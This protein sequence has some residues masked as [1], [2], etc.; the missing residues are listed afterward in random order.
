MLLKKS[1]NDFI[2]QISERKNKN[3]PRLIQ[4]DQKS[5]FFYL[6]TSR[7]AHPVRTV[8]IIGIIKVL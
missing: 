4:I 8:I 6:V 3:D 1:N 2:T 7:F 5:H